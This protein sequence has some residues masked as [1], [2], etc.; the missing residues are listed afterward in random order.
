MSFIIPTMFSGFRR[1]L[2]SGGEEDGRQGMGTTGIH[3]KPGALT[4]G[5]E[6]QE[7]A[8]L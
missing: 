6:N 2:L 7:K 8:R 3:Q 4:L 5:S 1:P